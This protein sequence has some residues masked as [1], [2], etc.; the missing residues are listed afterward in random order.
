MRSAWHSFDASCR[1][2]MCSWPAPHGGI[3]VDKRTALGNVAAFKNG[4]N[5]TK[6]ST[7]EIVK[8]VGVRNFQSNHWV[9]MDELDT[10]QIEGALSEP[11]TLRKHDILTVRSNGNRQLI[12]CCI[13]VGDV[14][15]KVSYS[16]FT[17]RIRVHSSDLDP[18]Y[19]IH[20][21]RS[22]VVREK[23]VKSGGGTNISN[24]NQK[25]LSVLAVRM[26]DR[27]E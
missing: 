25:G 9:P 12:G 2:H 11:Y 15:E 14:P 6:N 21:L 27:D 4:L 1:Q 10:V 8:I 23:L 19:L 3:H 18:M 17:I 7:G 16:G 13:L 24:L 22:G 5:F 26:P 20:Y